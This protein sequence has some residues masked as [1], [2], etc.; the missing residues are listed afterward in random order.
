MV[1]LQ[2]D[3]AICDL[4]KN[5]DFKI[6]GSHQISK[7][8]ILSPGPYFVYTAQGQG[9]TTHTVPLRWCPPPYGAYL[10]EFRSG[11]AVFGI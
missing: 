2:P 5:V 11:S 6:N 3:P 9:C 7:W 10:V 8:F 4:A 1:S